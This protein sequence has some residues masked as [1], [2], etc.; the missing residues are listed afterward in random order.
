MAIKLIKDPIHGNVEFSSFEEYFLHNPLINR[1]H[2]VLQ[3]S[4][5]YRVYPSAK[6][7]RFAH[8]I[9]VMYISSE[10]FRNGFTNSKEKVIKDYL[11]NKKKIIQKYIFQKN[12]YPELYI[13]KIEKLFNK[14]TD[15]AFNKLIGYS[16]EF[17]GTEFL[18][19]YSFNSLFFIKEKE[20]LPVYY[21]L[22]QAVRIYALTHDIGHLP[23]SHLTE[24]AIDGLANSISIT[25]SNENEKYFQK[26]LSS[27]HKKDIQTHENIGQNLIDFLFAKISNEIQTSDM[28]SDKK[29]AHLVYN[30]LI[31]K[32]VQ[33]MKKGK[34]GQFASLY[35]IISSD[36]DAD[37]IDFILRDGLYSGLVYKTG[38]VDRVL[39]MYCLC[40]LNKKKVADKFRFLPPIQ[41][42]NDIQEILFDRFRIYKYMV[43]HHKVKKLDFIV[44]HSLQLILKN[45]ILN[46]DS[47]VRNIDINRNKATDIILIANE[48]LTQ[49]KSYERKTFLFLQ[50]TDNW[51]ISILNEKYI[52]LETSPAD[53][54][55]I[56]NELKPLLSEIFTGK[57][58]FISLW[59]RDQDYLQFVDKYFKKFTSKKILNKSK[60]LV[61][62]N[63]YSNFLQD[64]I[65]DSLSPQV[66]MY[67]FLRTIQESDKNW[68]TR[69]HEYLLSKNIYVI[70]ANLKLKSGIKDLELVD[71]KNHNTQLP[72]QNISRT[73][74]II[75]Y[76]IF[77]SIQFFIYYKVEDQHQVDK[78]EN[79][80]SE[81]LVSFFINQIKLNKEK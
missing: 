69:L 65:K 39:R 58:H 67:Y 9:G 14:S 53:L 24:F 7:S 41:A 1:L 15:F 56:D 45:E 46:E 52:S 37:R 28:P 36:L 60:R 18:S 31:L 20:L 80:I 47:K 73:N 35:R 29:C 78:I 49:N 64:F 38:D 51:L 23:L 66:R 12:I 4:M 11:L 10:M 79:H 25:S 8:S 70:V 72:F 22:L 74:E 68:L 54:N 59:K 55:E 5:A 50:L 2:N 42:L 40:K 16:N 44:L 43:N 75:K 6:T 34:S 26:K 71:L 17:F 27:L 30:H 57:K 19:T 62:N 81:F 77:N 61:D 33:L 48:V 63:L 32:T 76:E 3:N 13:D 21:I